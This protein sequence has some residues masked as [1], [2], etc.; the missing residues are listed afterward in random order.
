MS[1][2]TG[3][4]W[5]INHLMLGS[6]RLSTSDNYFFTLIRDCSHIIFPPFGLRRFFILNL[7]RRIWLRFHRSKPLSYKTDA[8]MKVL[9]KTRATPGNSAR[10][11]FFT[12]KFCCHKY[13][14]KPDKFR[15]RI[16]WFRNGSKDWNKSGQRQETNRRR[17]IL[18]KS[19]RF[20][21]PVF[22]SAWNYRYLFSLDNTGDD[23]QGIWGLLNVATAGKYR[24]LYAG[25]KGGGRKRIKTFLAPW[26]STVRHRKE[27]LADWHGVK[28]DFNSNSTRPFCPKNAQRFQKAPFFS[29]RINEELGFILI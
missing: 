18:Y 25:I 16:L 4:S 24:F 1:I 27:D 11:Y 17:F 9:H 8:R 7:Q 21:L 15:L 22:Y 3:D 29:L 12:K 23:R 13:R 10:K 6:L 2:I 26:R 5:T 14:Q 28:E 20:P 19:Y